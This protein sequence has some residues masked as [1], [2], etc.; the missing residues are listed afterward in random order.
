MKRIK[1]EIKDAGAWTDVHSL[2][3]IDAMY[4]VVVDIFVAEGNT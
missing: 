1:V 3:H 2:K 4:Q